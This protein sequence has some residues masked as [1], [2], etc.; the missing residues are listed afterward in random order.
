VGQAEI[1]GG[2]GVSRLVAEDLADQTR[3]VFGTRVDREEVILPR[4]ALAVAQHTEAATA[5]LPVRLRWLKRARQANG[6]A[7]T[8]GFDRWFYVTGFI[9][10]VL[11]VGFA[12]VVTTAQRDIP[13]TDHGQ[14]CP[15]DPLWRLV[16]AKRF[17]QSA[18][19][20]QKARSVNP[21]TLPTS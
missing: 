3:T 11:A 4:V 21:V 15:R 17:S 13:Y 18:C 7:E 5:R 19:L 12:R 16:P 6:P 1:E 8:A 20:K 14:T 9:P 2:G 10:Q